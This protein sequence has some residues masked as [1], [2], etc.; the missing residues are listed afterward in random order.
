[1]IPFDPSIEIY[2]ALSE[3]GVSEDELEPITP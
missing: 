2:P 3:L 1:M